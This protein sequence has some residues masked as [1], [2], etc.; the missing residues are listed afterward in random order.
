MNRNHIVREVAKLLADK[1]EAARAVKKT[2]SVMA[3]A[4]HNGERVV[5]TGFGTFSVKLRAPRRTRNPKTGAAVVTGP[6]RTVKFKPSKTF[7]I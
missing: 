6:R 7:P 3:E 4:L 1:T 2:F 5:I